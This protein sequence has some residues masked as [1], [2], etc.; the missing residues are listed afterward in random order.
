MASRL[1]R[2]QQAS[3]PG[4]QAVASQPA[5]HFLY[6]LGTQRPGGTFNQTVP[7]THALKKGLNNLLPLDAH[8]VYYILCWSHS[9]ARHGYATGLPANAKPILHPSDKSPN[10][11]R[12]ASVI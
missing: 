12:F 10:L 5:R 7:Y 2:R 11:N 6:L 9:S 8:D 1:D 3:R 4:L